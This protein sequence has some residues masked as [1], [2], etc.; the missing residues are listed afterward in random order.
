MVID[1]LGS[2][3]CEVCQL[4]FYEVAVADVGNGYRP[5]FPSVAEPVWADRPF[6]EDGYCKGLCP[7]FEDLQT[8][9][10]QDICVST[11]IFIKEIYAA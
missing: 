3:K 6:E 9:N 11:K 8:I 2:S 10:G 4:Y 1:H 7:A 5:K